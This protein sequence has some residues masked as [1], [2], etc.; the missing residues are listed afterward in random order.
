MV[1]LLEERI[2]SRGSQRYY[3]I[4]FDDLLESLF[5][6]EQHGDSCLCMM[7]YYLLFEWGG[8]GL[9]YEEIESL[10][11]TLDYPLSGYCH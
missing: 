7:R 9:D 2:H 1:E 8:H 10:F 6:E 5:P 4:M 3:F 11:D